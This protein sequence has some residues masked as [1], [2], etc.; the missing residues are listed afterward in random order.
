MAQTISELEKER[1]KLLEAIE[2]QA[3][4]LSKQ[5]GQ[6]TNEARPHTL[7]DWLNAAEQVV[8][9]KK[10]PKL[11][12]DEDYSALTKPRNT[13]QSSRPS[14]NPQ[15]FAEPEV[16]LSQEGRLSAQDPNKKKT[17][18]NP[19]QAKHA[20]KASFFGV[21]IMLSLL[22]TM[23]GVVYVAYNAI[24]NDIKQVMAIHTETL[25][26]MTELQ[27]EVLAIKEQ[28][29]KGGDSL[30]FDQLI[31][32]IEQQQLQLNDLNQA[33]AENAQQV[34]TGA[35]RDLQ[36][37]LERQMETRL[38][39]MLTQ[40]ALSAPEQPQVE[41]SVTVDPEPIVPRIEQKV[42]RLVETKSPVDPDVTWL[43]QQPAENFILQLA[44]MPDRKW[45]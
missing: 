14:F 32:R 6:S 16:S 8:P 20:Q 30:V 42:V 45:H 19:Q 21:V 27:V 37:N 34:S 22:L 5:R 31:D 43:K 12:Y 26:G 1:A 40:L 9:A 28:L 17:A 29:E 3:N 15:D 4:Q 13:A 44:S 18:N 38:Q 11:S 2:A 36:Q 10:E 35:L 24:Q 33:V 7:N 25:E 23:L 41:P 39:G